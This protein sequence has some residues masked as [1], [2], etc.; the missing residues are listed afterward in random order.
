MNVDRYLFKM[1]VGR[2]KETDVAWKVVRQNLTIL[3]LSFIK[4]L[5]QPLVFLS[6]S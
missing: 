2:D 1:E 3:N 4:E 6:H 5:N